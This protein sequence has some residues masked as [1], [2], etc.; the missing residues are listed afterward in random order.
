[1]GNKVVK[2]T[3]KP[4]H[5]CERTDCIRCANRKN[6]IESFHTDFLI[7]KY[8]Q[9]LLQDRK[10]NNEESFFFN[11]ILKSIDSERKEFENVRILHK[12]YIEKM[13]QENKN[14][15]L[16]FVAKASL[17]QA[18]NSKSEEI[19]LL[20]EKNARM[21]EQILRQ[22]RIINNLKEQIDNLE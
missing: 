17:L 6:R 2:M 21:E 16:K 8:L 12:L 1:V 14:I 18:H 10:R 20:K 13:N 15:K 7:Y 22:K 9:N 19:A 11:S 3:R 5:L 4:R